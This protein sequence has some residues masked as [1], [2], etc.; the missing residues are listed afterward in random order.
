[1][2]FV[3]KKLK[4]MKEHP[5]PIEQRAFLHFFFLVIHITKPRTK[6]IYTFESSVTKKSSNNDKKHSINYSFKLLKLRLPFLSH[7][8]IIRLFFF[9]Q[10]ASYIELFMFKLERSSSNVS[11]FW[12]NP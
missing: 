3:K 7:L 12:I 2:Y 1:M 10:N 5:K 8:L 9:I 4:R 6:L 11:S